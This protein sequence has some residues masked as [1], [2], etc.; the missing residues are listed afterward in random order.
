MVQHGTVH[1]DETDPETA[2]EESR[3]ERYSRTRLAGDVPCHADACRW[4]HG[5][6]LLGS[7]SERVLRITDQLAR[8]KPNDHLIV[9]NLSGR[10]DKDLA[11]VAEYINK[12]TPA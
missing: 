11:S 2:V 7:E 5:E 12:K 9:V 6:K 10:G 3:D 1:V 8:G 4:R